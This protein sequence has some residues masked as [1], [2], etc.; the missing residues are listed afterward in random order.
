MSFIDILSDF[1]DFARFFYDQLQYKTDFF[2][3]TNSKINECDFLVIL[4]HCV[5]D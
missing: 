2:E 4:H 1:P 5:S 3:E